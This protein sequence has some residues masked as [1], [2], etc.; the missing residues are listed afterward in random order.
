[1]RPPR[2]IFFAAL[3]LACVVGMSV[4][5]SL[6]LSSL[7]TRAMSELAWKLMGTMARH[8]AEEADLQA[9]FSDSLDRESRDRLGR[10]LFRGLSHVPELARLKVWDLEGTVVWSDD[11]RLIGRHFPENRELRA[12]LV[13][14]DIVVGLPD[15][16]KPDIAGERADFP[17]VAEI[18]VPVT[19]PSSGAVVG[20]V[21]IYTTA[22]PLFALVRR[23]RFAV[24]S[25][26]GLG[27]VVLYL[28]L[29][30]VFRYANQRQT[31]YAAQLERE[32][33]E[34]TKDLR[35]AQ[36]HLIQQ[37]RL[38]ALGQM[39]SG[40]AHDFNNALSLIIGRAELLL[41]NPEALGDRGKVTRYVTAI[42][43]GAKD[44]AQIVERLREFYRRREDTDVF[45]AVD[46]NRIAEQAVSLTKPRWNAEALAQGKAVTVETDLQP[47]PP[48]A[49]HDPELREMLTNL[50]LNAVDAMPAGGTITVRTRVAVPAGGTTPPTAALAS[51][52]CILIEVRDTGTGMTEEVRRR[53]FEPFFSTKG[54]R[55]SGLGLAMVFGTVTRHEGS[56]DVQSALGEGTTVSVYLPVRTPDRKE[57]PALPARPAGPLRVLVVDDDP[58]VR[59]VLTEYLT[60]DGHTVV[61]A[62][63]GREGLKE[64]VAS[65]F[66]VVVTDRV[67]PSLGGE[68]FAITARD[69]AF[70]V[71]IILLTGFGSFIDPATEAPRG[72]DLV[73]AKPVTLESF[74]QAL[75][76]AQASRRPPR[77]ARREA[78]RPEPGGTA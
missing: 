63:N 59:D 8:V 1:M 64:L 55:G 9:M 41:D 22:E 60:R 57:R 69:M 25:I 14:R 76:T 6:A 46:V 54:E 45:G 53:C 66:D 2:V 29:L 39:A 67:M 71:P 61:T 23:G 49:G 4:L 17:A 52:P 62:A 77:E 3:S 74:R 27:S 72:V 40:I 10:R 30:P 12:A 26:S 43:S 20:A 35:Q 42:S 37:E 65:A 47:L 13:S 56:I 32:V 28:L 38:H 5:M 50:I 19:S 21:E 18:Y 16:R 70:D 11:A 44:A 68:Q 34:R 73:V 36:Q 58:A 75:A 78:Q 51:G 33:A 7:L 24:W 15:L 48:I 31:A